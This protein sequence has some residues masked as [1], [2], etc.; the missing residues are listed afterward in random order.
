MNISQWPISKIL[1][2]PDHCFG[3]RFIMSVCLRGVGD[4]VAW[5]ITELALP[6]RCVLWE[7]HIG[8]TVDPEYPGGLR[9]AL[10]DQ[11]PTL[12]AQ[13]TALEPL[14]QGVGVQGP[15]PRDMA[16]TLSRFTYLSRLKMPIAAMGRRIVMELVGVEQYSVD[17]YGLFVISSF[18]TEVADCYT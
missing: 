12:T 9:F 4:E 15:E 18:P 17:A 3:R 16:F 13:M 6:E 2:L 11:L 1:A 8:F 7:V 14:L 10:G 5:D